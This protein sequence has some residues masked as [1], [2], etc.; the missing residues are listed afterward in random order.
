MQLLTA[1]DR[2]EED[3]DL[4]VERWLDMDIYNTVSEEV[5]TLRLYCTAVPPL[6]IPW[7]TLLIAHSDMV[8]TLWRNDQS[9]TKDEA[10][11]ELK[12]HDHAACLEVLRKRCRRY[13]EEMRAAAE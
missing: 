6:S 8:H 4:M 7:V 13:L 12:R 1:L 9:R 2:Y 3:M 10:T 5:E 11:L